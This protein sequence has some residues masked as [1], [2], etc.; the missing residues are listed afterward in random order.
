LK[1]PTAFVFCSKDP[2]LTSK[3]LVNFSKDHEK[4]SLEVAF[5]DKKVLDKSL[6]KA[7]AALPPKEVLLARVIGG[8]KAPLSGLANVL[9]GTLRNLVSVL[10]QV[11]KQKKG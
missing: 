4:L 7:L 5:I 9:G 8:I 2:V 1:D 10:D 11:A 3:S 6:I